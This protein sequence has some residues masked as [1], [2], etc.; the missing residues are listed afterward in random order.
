MQQDIPFYVL[1]LFFL[2]IPT[3]LV[4]PL[5]DGPLYDFTAYTE[6]KDKPEEPLYG[7]G[8]L[9]SDQQSPPAV[10][11]NIVSSY[12]VNNIYVP[13]LVLHNLTQ[14]T[15]YTFSAWVRVKGSSSAMIRATLETEKET[16]DCIGTVSAKL[17]CWS[18]LKGGFVLNWPSNLSIIFFQNADGKDINIEV[19]SPSLQ[20][21][22]KQQWET[23]QQYTINTKRK[24]AV[25]IHVSDSNGRRLQGA[26]ICIE[27]ISKEFLFGSAIAHTILGNVPY[28]NWFVK[29][30]NAAVF[31]N[32][33]KWYATEPDEGKVNYTISDQML[34][35]VRTKN[36]VA[37][38]HNIFW[39]DPKY[40][41][42][43]VL[44]LTGTQLQSAVNSR[45]QS[46]MSQYRNEFIHWD[47]SNE[48]LH[49]D[50]YEQ[51]LGS[52]A[53][54]HFFETAHESDP[55]STLFMNDFNV[56]ETCSD[57]NS[58]VDAYISRVKELRRNGILMDGIG[59]EGHFTIPNPPLIRAILDK[60]ATLGLPIWLTEVD[61]SKT[62]D[63]DSQQVL[64]EGFSH[65]AVNGIMLWTAYHPNGCYQMCLTDKNFKNLA[66]GDVVDKLL[67]EWKTG[68]VEGVTDV[69]GSYSF[70]GF[71][72][73]YTVTVNYGNRTTKSTFSL[74]RGQ[75]T[76]HFTITL[77]SNS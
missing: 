66:A 22:T 70:Y 33:L 65:P 11:D 40:N 12:V 76:E 24:R 28:Q 73:E 42:P 23:N 19:A 41:P 56:V 46:L 37:R 63:T 61:I 50:F 14:G 27:Q 25:T 20:P 18:F 4:S 69:H 51:R 34:Q 8:I 48:M 36:I 59:L 49:F 47:V 9:K 67:Q 60:L 6:C 75:E 54:L 16:Y 30:F 55:L 45:I 29:R 5:Y 77:S 52:D 74:S 57:V 53:T 68:R 3:S 35:F 31:E 13:S 7:G 26:S 1:I 32:E 58:T 39:E 15:I 71:L 43:W 38:G 64:R 62:I 72:G 2:L 21:F 10:Q 44:N 17:G